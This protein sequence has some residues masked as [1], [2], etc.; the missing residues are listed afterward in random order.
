MFVQRLI[1]ISGF[2][3]EHE[4]FKLGNKAASFEFLFWPL[5]NKNINKFFSEGINNHKVK[6]LS[7]L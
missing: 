4:K 1:E 3:V 7:D 6:N 5:R 2:I